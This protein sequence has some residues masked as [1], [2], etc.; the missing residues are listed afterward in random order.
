[1]LNSC[2]LQSIYE[3]AD[4]ETIYN[5]MKPYCAG[6]QSKLNL[7]DAYLSK[8]KQNLHIVICFSPS[9]S[10]LRTRLRKFPSLVNCCSIDYIMDWPD[11][12]LVNV[13]EQVYQFKKSDVQMIDV[14]Q[15]EFLKKFIED[16]A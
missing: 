14:P 12:A 15:L 3:A 2:D 16:Q 6:N 9:G 8:V 4:M 11:D 7:Y 10:T 5:E 13:A 1:M